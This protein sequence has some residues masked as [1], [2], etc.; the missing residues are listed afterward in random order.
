VGYKTATRVDALLSELCVKKGFCL[1]PDAQEALIN[2]PPGDR[3]SFVDAI[4]IADGIDPVLCDKQIRRWVDEAVRDWIFDDGF[5]KG[6][7]SGLPL[8]PPAAD[9]N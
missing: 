9:P 4:L 3:N 1:P 8:L 6:T 7:R 5:G 2:N